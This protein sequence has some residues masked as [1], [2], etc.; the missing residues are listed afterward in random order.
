M[1]LEGKNILISGGTGRLGR[2]LIPLLKERRG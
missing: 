1:R 2:E